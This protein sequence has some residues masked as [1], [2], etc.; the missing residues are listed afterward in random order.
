MINVSWQ[1]CN[2]ENRVMLVVGQSLY[3]RYFHKIS[4]FKKCFYKIC[5][6]YITVIFNDKGKLLYYNEAAYILVQ[7]EEK[8]PLILNITFN[9]SSVFE[10]LFALP[11]KDIALSIF[12]FLA[13]NIS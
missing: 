12:S 7:S 13:K 10:D 1:D 2:L 3:F 6:C 11:K 8:H 5:Y 9:N 4:R